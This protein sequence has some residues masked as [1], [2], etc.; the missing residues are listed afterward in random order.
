MS[1]VPSYH[2]EVTPA[3]YEAALAVK[4]AALREQF[5]PLLLD[6]VDVK[7]FPSP[8]S[9]F[10]SRCRFQVVS[11]VAEEEEE[12][13]ADEAATAGEGAGKSPS[14]RRRRRRRRRLSYRLWDGG[15][16][17]VRVADFPMALRS[18]NV[19]MP[20]VLRLA[21]ANDELSEG[22]EAVHFLAARRGGG[23]LITLVYSRPIGKKGNGWMNEG[24][25][26]GTL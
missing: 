21:E 15:G 18:I 5:A 20:A 24:L 26:L 9:H 16:P 11:E 13:A 1:V 22:L 19:V 25:S 7:V 23:I 6:G 8:P 10:R 2:D 17:T 12:E 4:V 3:N 14:S